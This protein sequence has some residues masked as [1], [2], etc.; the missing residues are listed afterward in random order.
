MARAD[1]VDPL[2]LLMYAGVM[3]EKRLSEMAE[4]AANGRL[5]SVEPL[6][7]ARW[8][9]DTSRERSESAARRVSEAMTKSDEL[10][11]ARTARR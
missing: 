7:R 11:R 9:L 3:G 6:E 1:R 2:S 4:A 5:V 10:C 8:E